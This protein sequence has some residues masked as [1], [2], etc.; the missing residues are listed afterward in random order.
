MKKQFLAIA[1]SL[2]VVFV[3]PLDAAIPVIDGSNLQENILTALRTLQSNLNEAKMI[4]HQIEQLANDA[5]NLAKIDFSFVE[6]FQTEMGD[7]FEAV[8]K[9]QGLMQNYAALED[10]FSALY[11]EFEAEKEQVPLKKVLE[12]SKKWLAESR[13]MVKGA[14]LTGAK[15]LETLPKTQEHLSALLETSGGAEGIL[16]AAQTGNE[17]SVQIGQSLLGLEAQLATYS[18]AHMAFMMRQIEEEAAQKNRMDH[19]LDG[20]EKLTG[21]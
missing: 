1:V 10:K 13:E 17:I 15:A 11:P 16:Q 8:G 3:R 9:V 21:K 4:K 2:M 19:V 5:L 12:G 7:L 14:A 20:Y 6:N 18:Q